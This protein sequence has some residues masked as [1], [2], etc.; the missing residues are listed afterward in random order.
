MAFTETDGRR[1]AVEMLR[2]LEE[3]G[4]DAANIDDGIRK[5]TGYGAQRNVA[6][7]YLGKLRGNADLERGF[8]ALLSD[9]IASTLDGAIPAPE[10]YEE[11]INPKVTGL[12]RWQ[13]SR[14]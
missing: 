5:Q 10:F 6:A 1:L 4:A 12:G 11:R 3:V 13:G 9:F 2:E 8:G 7:E 14:R